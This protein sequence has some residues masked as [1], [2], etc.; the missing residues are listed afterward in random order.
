M[1]LHVSLMN[2]VDYF[3]STVSFEK[4]LLR[5]LCVGERSFTSR[6]YVLRKTTRGAFI[7]TYESYCWVAVRTLA[8]PYGILVWW[9]ILS[10]SRA[11]VCRYVKN[12]QPYLPIWQ[13]L[14]SK[15]FISSYEIVMKMVAAEEYKGINSFIY[16]INKRLCEN[17]KARTHEN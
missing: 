5:D 4:I 1:S 15:K 13:T 8:R 14:T 2:T 16:L 7:W 10:V 6:I 12:K 9:I 17:R 11:C 3:C